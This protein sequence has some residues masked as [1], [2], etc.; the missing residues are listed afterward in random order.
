MIPDSNKGCFSVKQ[1]RTN[2]ENTESN[3][4]KDSKENCKKSQEHALINNGTYFKLL[5]QTK[6]KAFLWYKIELIHWITNATQVT[7]I[8]KYD[9]KSNAYNGLVSIKSLKKLR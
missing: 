2:I 4:S 7:R 3:N 1:N 5:Y 6:N 8:R 9:K